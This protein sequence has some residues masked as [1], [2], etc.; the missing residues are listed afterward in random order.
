[1]SIISNIMQVN[2]S[3]KDYPYIQEVIEEHWED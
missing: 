1:M 2:E 3:D